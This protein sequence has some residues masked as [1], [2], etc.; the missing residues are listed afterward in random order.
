MRSA[1]CPLDVVTIADTSL[2]AAHR[3]CVHWQLWHSKFKLLM[4]PLKSI[5]DDEIVLLVDGNDV[6]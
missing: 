4:E 3:C 2:G 1:L 5:P 6:M